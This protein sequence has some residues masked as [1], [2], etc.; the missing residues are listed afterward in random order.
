VSGSD[1]SDSPLLH[2]LA[3]EG[4]RVA[5]GEDAAN[6]DDDT[7]RV[8]YSEAIVTKPDISKEA[9]LMA[10]AELAKARQLGIEN[11]S[12]PHALAELFNAK[13]RGVAV[14]GSHGK[15]TTTAMLGT[16]FA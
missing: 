6:L 15:S 8:V 5:V 14:T 10:N 7:D 4:I 1:V 3:S 11:M 2:A 13:D 12:Y 16:V 9:N